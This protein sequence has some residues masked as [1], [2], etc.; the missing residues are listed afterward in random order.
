MIKSGKSNTSLAAIGHVVLM[1]FVFLNVLISLQA[2]SCV[3]IPKSA[4]VD[5]LNKSIKAYSTQNGDYNIP[6]FTDF[7]TDCVEL[8]LISYQGTDDKALYDLTNP[9]YDCAEDDTLEDTVYGD[10]VSGAVQAMDG[11][12]AN[13]QYFQY[14]HGYSMIWRVLLMFM[15]ASQIRVFMLILYLGIM[16]A[17]LVR[18]FYH[19]TIFV[20]V[21]LTN[22]LIVPYGFRSL[23]YIPIFIIMAIAIHLAYNSKYNLPTILAC[24]GVATAFFDFLTSET[25]TLTVPL[26]VYVLAAECYVSYGYIIKSAIAWLGGYLATYVMKWG[27]TS[28]FMRESVFGKALEEYSVHNNCS[29]GLAAIKFNI[30][31]LAANCVSLN[32]TFAVVAVLVALVLLTA[33]IVIGYDKTIFA[34][35][36][37]ALVPYIRYF[38][39]AG[40]SFNFSYLTF[41]AQAI[42]LPILLYIV[43]L[44]VLQIKSI[45]LTSKQRRKLKK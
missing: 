21:L 35:C 32:V 12:K 18:V 5:N 42:E 8:N 9:Y 33:Y 29:S 20:T 34:L 41:R 28:V 24:I 36:C 26:V 14:W 45:K 17:F 40:H 43:Y 16:G 3:L 6:T 15:T 30:N 7:Q 1:A 19:K 13:A 38:V 23:S 31:D 44:I 37:I 25:L 22:L 27:L 4:I 10:Y 39:L 11:K 2:F